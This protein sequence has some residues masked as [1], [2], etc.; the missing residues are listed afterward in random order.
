MLKRIW[1]IF[2]RDIRINF[3]EMMTLYMI[4]IPI[5]LAVAINFLS[6]GINDT[7]VNLA[8]VEGENAEQAEYLD[9]FAHVLLL[10]DQQAVEKRVGARDDV[11]GILADGDSYYILA[12]G[13]EPESVVEYAK[14]LNVLYESDVQLEDARSEV[15][16]FGR[17]VP[18]LKK[19]LVN[20]L[21]LLISMLAGMLI[22]MNILEEKVD[23]TVAAINVT[24]TSRRAFIM[25]KG[26]TGIFVAIVSSIAV[27][28][29]TGFYTVNLGQAALVVLSVTMIS[30]II[31]FLQGL[32]SDDFME[33]A[34]S[35]KLLFLPMAGSIAGYEFV[36]GNWQ[37]FFYWSPFYWAYRAN[38]VILNQTGT[39][40]QVLLYVG[41]IIV[42][43]GAIY[44]LLAP[45]I[46]KGLE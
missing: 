7:S 36:R 27:I 6:P 8:L 34:G 2:L 10:K 4:F 26:F 23:Q 31:G 45:R 33:A 37:A 13:N 38:D 28:A 16:E 35:V 11:M 32:N 21:L 44:A 9:D 24:P 46:I 17:T 20:V 39:W 19:M 14:L 40:P 1:F 18:P 29:I 41:I 12:Q 3:R 15:I 22:S 42:I 5:V 25:G 43:C 30:L